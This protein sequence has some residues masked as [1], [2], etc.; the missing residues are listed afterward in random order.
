MV[1]G[2]NNGNNHN[3]KDQALI[4]QGEMKKEIEYMDES[5]VKVIWSP[6]ILARYKIYAES[7]LADYAHMVFMRGSL[8][9]ER[10]LL[11]GIDGNGKVVHHKDGDIIV[12]TKKGTDKTKLKDDM[13]K[14]MPSIPEDVIEKDPTFSYEF[15]QGNFYDI[16]NVIQDIRTVKE[17]E[18]KEAAEGELK[19]GDKK[20]LAKNRDS[21]IGRAFR[22]VI[23]YQQP[24][25]PEEVKSDTIEDLE[26]IEDRKK[27]EEL[28]DYIDYRREKD[29]KEGKPLTFEKW[30]NSVWMEAAEEIKSLNNYNDEFMRAWGAAEAHV[31][32]LRDKYN[33]LENRA[34]DEADEPE[35]CA[36]KKELNVME[37]VLEAFNALFQE[38]E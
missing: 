9:N 3:L 36:V 25:V 27:Q 26:D 1:T 33:R 18:E 4:Q 2:N 14:N 20:L 28:D 5:A 37:A 29:K 16:D 11:Y 12:I 35:M 32:S 34:D 21:F 24:D 6:H 30:L 17:L 31:H 22:G 10:G 15:D 19:N 7:E 23:L 13:G 38:Q 8:A